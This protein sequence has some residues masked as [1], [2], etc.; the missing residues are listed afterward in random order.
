[1]KQS[2]LM[3]KYPIFDLCLDKSETDYASVDEVISALKEKIDAHPKVVFIDIFDHYSHTK[4]LGGEIGEG[5]VDAKNLLFCFGVKL[6]KPHV[7]SVRPRSIGI[8]DMGDHFHISFLEPPM[9][10]ATNEM[11]SWC[12]GLRSKQA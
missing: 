7:L 3:E 6:P 4:S 1:M 9:E 10:L 8:A 11:E 12:L 2:V 5:I